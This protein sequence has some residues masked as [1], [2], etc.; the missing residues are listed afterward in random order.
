MFFP[1]NDASCLSGVFR[2]TEKRRKAFCQNIELHWSS[3]LREMGVIQ[4]KQLSSFWNVCQKSSFRLLTSRQQ[5]L[6]FIVQMIL[7][8]ITVQMIRRSNEKQNSITR[9]FFVSTTIEVKLAVF[10]CGVWRT[11]L[12][13]YVR[14]VSKTMNRIFLGFLGYFSNLVALRNAL[15]W[16]C[17]LCTFLTPIFLPSCHASWSPGSVFF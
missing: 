2:I 8:K 11:E 3:S 10:I 9:S 16:M 5:L 6:F 13:L 17:S 1:A 15:K 12:T 14:T 7:S 4:R